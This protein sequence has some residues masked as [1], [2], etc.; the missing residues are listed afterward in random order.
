MVSTKG[1]HF[2]NINKFNHDPLVFP[3][4]QDIKAQIKA[5]KIEDILFSCINHG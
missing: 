2:D 4:N 5:N 3:K 1:I